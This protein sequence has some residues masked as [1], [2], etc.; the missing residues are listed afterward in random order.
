MNYL[1]DIK[2]FLGKEVEL[3][4]QKIND[5]GVKINQ[6]IKEKFHTIELKITFLKKEDNKCVL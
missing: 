3:L 2:I 4:T 1:R 6:F 5:S